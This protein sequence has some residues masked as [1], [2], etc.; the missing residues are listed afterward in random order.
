MGVW[1]DMAIV[2]TSKD[3]VKID[4]FQNLFFFTLI[5]KAFSNITRY[6]REIDSFLTVEYGESNALPSEV[7]ALWK[8]ETDREE[9]R[10]TDR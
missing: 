7:I 10:Q 5:G 4:F 3:E 6:R 2:M 9:D 1:R 8:R